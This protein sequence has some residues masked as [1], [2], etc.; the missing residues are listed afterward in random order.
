MVLF[1]QV[2]FGLAGHRIGEVE[3][4]A[5]PALCRSCKSATR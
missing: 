2:A 1:V 4:A 3:S 5:I